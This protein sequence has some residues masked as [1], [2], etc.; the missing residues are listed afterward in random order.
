[1]EN[2]GLSDLKYTKHGIKVVDNITHIN[3]GI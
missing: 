1:L 3:V 2:D